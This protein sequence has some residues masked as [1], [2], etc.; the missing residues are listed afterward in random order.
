M[1]LRHIVL[2]Y[3]TCQHYQPLRRHTAANILLRFG[4]PLAATYAT[5]QPYYATDANT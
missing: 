2:R 1:L 4:E 3:Y 5:C